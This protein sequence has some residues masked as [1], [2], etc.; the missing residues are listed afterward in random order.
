MT[1]T[2]SV[3]TL[4]IGINSSNLTYSVITLSSQQTRVG[5]VNCCP[6]IPFCTLLQVQIDRNQ[7]G[8]VKLVT[9]LKLS[10]PYLKYFTRLHL[11]EPGPCPQTSPIGP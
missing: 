1:V 3:E 2:Q 8:E 7:P 11:T 9:C 4:R 10:L 5:R 6:D